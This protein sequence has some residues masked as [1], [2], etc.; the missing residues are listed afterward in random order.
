MRIFTKI[1]IV[2][3]AYFLFRISNFTFE[4]L[5]TNLYTGSDFQFTI[6]IL[7]LIISLTSSL[8]LL[9][10]I[11]WTALHSLQRYAQRPIPKSKD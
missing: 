6:T 5:V 2:V 4:S 11:I 10:Y 7:G 9:S 8:L 1:F 3:L